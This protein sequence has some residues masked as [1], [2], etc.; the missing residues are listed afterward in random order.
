MSE[1][2]MKTVGINQLA[3]ARFTQ[4]LPKE[5]LAEGW[6]GVR[7]RLR[8]PLFY[9]ATMALCG[10]AVL[11]LSVLLIGGLDRLGIAPQYSFSGLNLTLIAG[12]LLLLFSPLRARIQ[13]SRAVAQEASATSAA[14][15]RRGGKPVGKLLIIRRHKRRSKAL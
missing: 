8:A 3:P 9:G 2:E 11:L 12:C 10:M 1:I 14:V 5:L 15:K 13:H 7:G 4:P 6:R